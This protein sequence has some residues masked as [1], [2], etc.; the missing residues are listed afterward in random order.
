MKLKIPLSFFGERD[1]SREITGDY[2]WKFRNRKIDG[3][4]YNLE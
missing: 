4:L 2:R 3:Y 1:F